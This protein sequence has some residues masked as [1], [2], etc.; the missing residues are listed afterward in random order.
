MPAF[1]RHAFNFETPSYEWLGIRWA[2]TDF[3]VDADLG[4]IAEQ[5]ARGI[6]RHTTVLASLTE[7][8]AAPG[9]PF[10]FPFIGAA[11]MEV[12]NIAPRDDGICSFLLHVAWP[13]PLHVRL[14]VLVANGW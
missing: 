5:G 7:L 9:Y 6:D 11:S 14:S 8:A 1:V 13:L 2:I 10:D 3:I 12:R 4:T